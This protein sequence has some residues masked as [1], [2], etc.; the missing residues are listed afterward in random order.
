MQLQPDN[1]KAV[2]SG[3][4][5]QFIDLMKG[6]CILLVVLFHC[7]IYNE[8]DTTALRT[9]RMPLYFVLSGLFFKDYGS[10]LRLVEKKVNK[11]IIPFLFFV[12]LGILV[13]WMRPD[14]SSLMEVLRRHNMLYYCFNGPVWFLLSLFWLN[15]IFGVIRVASD[16]MSAR[17]RLRISTESA[18][19]WLTT[20]GVAAAFAIGCYILHQ[21]I[22]IPFRITQALL[23]FPFF[24]LGYLLRRTSLLYESPADITWL[25]RS[26]RDMLLCIVGL[27]LLVIC[28]FVYDSLGRIWIHF[29][30]LR[31]TGNLWINYIF[32]S[33]M[34][35][36]SI[37]V[38]K[39]IRYLPLISYIGRYSIIVLGSHWLYVRVFLSAWRHFF[40][41]DPHYILLCCVTILLSLATIPVMLRLCPGLVA[42]RDIIRFS[43]GT[44]SGNRQ[45]T[46]CQEQP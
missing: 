27:F 18:S 6:I 14:T 24:Y 21:G 5:I 12:F 35:I 16:W 32:S 13:M 43:R 2:N 26:R 23:A 15:I 33:V 30:S 28:W 45:C 31:Y 37:L 1:N 40:S 42:Q 7:D 34:V 4:R 39:V 46:S 20:L 44:G 3:G 29:A 25:G 22:K 41:S 10:L 38:S 36:A 17:L 8:Y 9:L 11:L 19:I